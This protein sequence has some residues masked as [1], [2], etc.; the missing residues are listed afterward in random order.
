MSL[1]SMK[2][3]SGMAPQDQQ[4]PQTQAFLLIAAASYVKKANFVIRRTCCG[5]AHVRSQDKEA[6]FTCRFQMISFCMKSYIELIQNAKL[7]SCQG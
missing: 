2:E 1:S 7:M 3:G 4:L 5:R 6:C